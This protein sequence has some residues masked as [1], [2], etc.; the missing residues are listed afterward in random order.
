MAQIAGFHDLRE[1]FGGL[2]KSAFINTASYVV[3][4]DGLTPSTYYAKN[5]TTGRID[6]S[7]ASPLTI[8]NAMSTALPTGG[9]VFVKAGQYTLDNYWIITAPIKFYGEGKSTVIDIIPNYPNV[10]GIVLIR[11]SDIEIH[12]FNFNITNSAIG[13][14]GTNGILP[15]DTVIY[16][17]VK[18]Q[19]CMFTGRILSGNPVPN[20]ATDCTLLKVIETGRGKGWIITDNQFFMYGYEAVTVALNLASNQYGEGIIVSDNYMRGGY[21]GVAIEGYSKNCVVSDNV[22]DI[23]AADDLAYGVLICQGSRQNTVSGNTISAEKGIVWIRDESTENT[24]TGNVGRSVIGFLIDNDCIGNT[25]SNNLAVAQSFT[26]AQPSTGIYVTSIGAK[27]NTFKGNIFIGFGHDGNYA[28]DIYGRTIIKGNDFINCHYAILRVGS[29]GTEIIGNTF[30]GYSTRVGLYFLRLFGTSVTLKTVIKENTFTDPSASY[31][32]TMSAALAGATT[33]TVADASKFI[34]GG[35]VITSPTGFAVEYH[36]IS[37]IN[38]KDNTITFWEALT[39][40]HTAGDAVTG[41]AVATTAV[42]EEAAGAVQF[43]DNY[44]QPSFTAP[45]QLHASSILEMNTLV[46]PFVQGTTFLSAAPFGW[47]IDANTEYAIALGKLPPYVTRVYRW[48]VWAVSLVAEAD[49]M[50]LEI[51]GYGGTDNEAYTAETVAVADKPSASVNF[52]VNDYI[53]WLLT[54][55]DDADIDD[56]IG[57]DSIMIKVLHEAAGGADCETDAVFL[58]VEIDYV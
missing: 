28:F 4:S 54:A 51:E 18:I 1:P 39:N 40:N 52:A 3:W 45:M 53:H 8:L 47:E 55:T 34:I 46:F 31:T 5:G 20:S 15:L 57:G 36:I 50:R 10:N 35:N 29:E 27:D 13:G 44:I 2:D 58:C 21:G 23:R 42:K 25:F 41:N 16:S 11:S 38:Y 17:N 56:M 9:D 49:S 22:M 6:Y 33:I 7:S 24:I 12:G 19:N 30:K 48:R 43:T 26:S 14:V 32:T 37:D